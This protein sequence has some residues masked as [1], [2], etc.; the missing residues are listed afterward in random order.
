MPLATLQ[1]HSALQL[2]LYNLK[3]NPVMDLN[4]DVAQF[5]NGMILVKLPENIAAGCYVLQVKGL[6]QSGST[7]PSNAMLQL[8]QSVIIAK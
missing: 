3:G 4:L 8:S 5:V 2:S 6:N 1:K 7:A